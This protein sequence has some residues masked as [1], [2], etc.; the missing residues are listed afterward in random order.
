MNDVDSDCIWQV[1]V[2]PSSTNIPASETRI[3]GGDD[4]YGFQTRIRVVKVDGEWPD[5]ISAG[6]RRIRSNPG[7]PCLQR[8]AF[9]ETVGGGTLTLYIQPPKE[10][11]KPD[12]LKLFHG[13]F[14]DYH[15]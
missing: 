7:S 10:L 11:V 3:W 14:L 13:S 5:Y 15:L 9:F 4:P 6:E 12:D 1:V 2:P 8:Y